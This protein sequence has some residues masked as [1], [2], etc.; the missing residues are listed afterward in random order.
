MKNIEFVRRIKSKFVTIYL[1]W[2]EVEPFNKQKL[3]YKKE[4]SHEL[5]PMSYVI[6]Y[7]NKHMGGVY[8]LE[9][10]FPFFVF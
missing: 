1:S 3:K 9:S 7:C 5:L 6:N 4:K 8:L 2:T 10:F